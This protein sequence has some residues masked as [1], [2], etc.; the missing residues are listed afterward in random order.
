VRADQV[1]PVNFAHKTGCA[2]ACNLRFIDE[3]DRVA[4]YHRGKLVSLGKAKSK[5]PFTRLI[6]K[7][8]DLH[9][10]GD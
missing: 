2:L 3:N 1:N 8:R 9:A 6:T 5:T 10:N 7:V 4:V